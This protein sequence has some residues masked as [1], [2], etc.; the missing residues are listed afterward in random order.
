MRGSIAH[1]EKI[2]VYVWSFELETG[3]GEE[4]ATQQLKGH[5]K[6]HKLHP[7]S[8]DVIEGFS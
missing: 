2:K 7:W 6:N 8:L 3:D 1:S 5:S 4:E